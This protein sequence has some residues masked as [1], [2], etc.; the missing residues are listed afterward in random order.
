VNGNGGNGKGDGVPG[1]HKHSLEESD[2]VKK[3]SVLRWQ[4]KIEKG[5]RKKSQ[6]SLFVFIESQLPCFF[7]RDIPLLCYGRACVRRGSS[8]PTN[9]RI[10]HLDALGSSS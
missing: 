3:N 7:A 9:K 1:P 2:R 6:V 4:A 10:R 5:D 8:S